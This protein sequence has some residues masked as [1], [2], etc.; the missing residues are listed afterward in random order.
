MTKL[1]SLIR[2]GEGKRLELLDEWNKVKERIEA[3]EVTAFAA[4]MTLRDGRT[5]QVWCH[6]AG[7]DSAHLLT[8]SA[9][10]LLR[11]VSDWALKSAK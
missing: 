2:A 5:A 3:G 11:R 8:A 1:V 9:T 4:A 7:T 6:P 10:Y